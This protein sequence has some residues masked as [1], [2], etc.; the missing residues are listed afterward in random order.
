M[1]GSARGLR[2]TDWTSVPARASAAPARRA[3]RTRGTRVSRTKVTVRPARPCAQFTTSPSSSLLSPT[4]TAVTIR[5]TSTATRTAVVVRKTVLVLMRSRSDSVA[6]AVSRTRTAMTIRKTAPTRLVTTPVGTATATS[7]GTRARSST[8]EPITS[9]APVRPAT[10]RLARVR[11]KPR[12]LRA[13]GRTSAGAHRPTN[14]MG[15]ARVT[16]AV[17]SRAA[18]TTVMTRVA[19]TGTPRPRAAS[20]PRARASTRRARSSSPM[21]P[22]TPIGATCST[23]SN[24]CCAMLPWFHWKMPSVSR[25][26]S[27]SSPSVMAVRPR[28]R[29][30]PARTSRTVPVPRPDSPRTTAAA[31]RPPRNATPEEASSGSER[32]VAA[33][34]PRAK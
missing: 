24:P 19:R 28:V 17:E 13:S 30:L 1:P 23:P 12:N 21:R 10:G 29:A 32:P 9:A 27:R 33:T 6:P 18:R 34:R 2:V 26:N 22:A 14:P 16:A 31:A 15:P 7:A 3:A 25:G 4:S 11:V 20:S 5:P 8:S